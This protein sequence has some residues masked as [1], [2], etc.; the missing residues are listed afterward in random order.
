MSRRPPPSF[1]AIAPPSEADAARE[2]EEEARLEA[3]ARRRGVARLETEPAG[4]PEAPSSPPPSSPPE[5]EGMAPEPAGDAPSAPVARKTKPSSPPAPVE[6]EVPEP[7]R[8]L[9]IELPVSVIRALKAQAVEEDCSVRHL[10]M[11]ALSQA[12]VAIP[13]TA[14]VPDGRRRPR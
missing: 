14:M 9:N 12:G 11:R 13:A 10:V 4:E 1:R 6:Q 8:A 2:A 3:L 5:D 7:Q